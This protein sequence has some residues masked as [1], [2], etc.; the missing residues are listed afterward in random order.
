MNPCN[1]KFES[2]KKMC[3]MQII[4]HVWWF[5]S[6]DGEAHPAYFAHWLHL[7]FLDR[8]PKAVI[9]GLWTVVRI[10]RLG[11]KS[12]LEELLVQ[13]RG[14]RFFLVSPAGTWAQSQSPQWPQVKRETPCYWPG[15]GTPCKLGSMGG[16]SLFFPLS[17]IPRWPLCVTMRWPQQ[18]FRPSEKMVSSQKDQKKGPLRSNEWQGTENPHY[19]FFR[20]SPVCLRGALDAKSCGGGWGGG[21]KL[22]P[23]FLARGR[24]SWRVDDC[25]PVELH[26]K[27]SD[28]YFT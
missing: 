25:A 10:G 9:W 11:G 2:P 5:I 7:D 23:T 17:F 15:H 28:F 3:N 20:L 26:V 27:K 13:W 24:P 12:D 14:S 4:S 8:K 16:I 1:N 21:L 6:Q 22:S 18:R 19:F